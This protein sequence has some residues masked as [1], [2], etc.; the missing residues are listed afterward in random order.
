MGDG[1]SKK[2]G[3]QLEAQ[4]LDERRDFLRLLSGAAALV[5]AGGLLACDGTDGVTDPDASSSS[6]SSSSSSASSSSSSSSAS[7]SSSSSSSSSASSSSGSSSSSSSG[8]S[9]SSSSGGSSSSARSAFGL[10]SP[11]RATA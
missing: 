11:P 10:V 6:S 9:S 2:G 3:G 4:T 5:G 8:G 7:S 1:K